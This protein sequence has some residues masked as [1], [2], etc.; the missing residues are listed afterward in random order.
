M[1]P[2]E[3]WRGLRDGS[4]GVVVGSGPSWTLRVVQAGERV[5]DAIVT[6]WGGA[7]G[8]ATP[9]TSGAGGWISWGGNVLERVYA[10]ASLNV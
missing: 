3:L 7:G 10:S 5:M 2:I 1:D 8:S 9:G 6:P 4:V